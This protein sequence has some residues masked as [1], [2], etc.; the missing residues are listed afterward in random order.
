MALELIEKVV[1]DIQ[2]ILNDGMAAKLNT[3]D[4]E[5]ADTITLDDIE[6]YH[7]AE[8]TAVPAGGYPCIFI[9]GD[10]SRPLK[11][12]TGWMTVAHDVSVIILATDMNTANLKRRLYRYARAVTEL[13]ITN[14]G[15]LGS[16]SLSSFRFS[17]TYGKSGTF[18]S[19]ASLLVTVTK[20]EAYSL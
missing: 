19:D 3:L 15:T 17:P 4:A 6:A 13:L 10:D 20:N 8:Q 1:D 12:N 18:L 5:Y 7:I 14:R 16:V 2:T 11:E 9:L